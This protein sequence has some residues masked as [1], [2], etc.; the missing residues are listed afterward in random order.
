MESLVIGAG[1]QLDTSQSGSRESLVFNLRAARFLIT[2]MFS[3]TG[4][5]DYMIVSALVFCRW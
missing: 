2:L 4:S 3:P 5:M 1:S